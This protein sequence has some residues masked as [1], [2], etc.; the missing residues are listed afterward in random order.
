MSGIIGKAIT[1]VLL[2]IS[3]IIYIYIICTYL[4]DNCDIYMVL[5]FKISIMSVSKHFK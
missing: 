3:N 4:F 2:Y 1:H 5:L